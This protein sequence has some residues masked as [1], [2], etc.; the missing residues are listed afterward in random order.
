VRK[1]KMP[2]AKGVFFFNA[3]R[4][5]E[6]EWPKRKIVSCLDDIDSLNSQLPQYL[7]K[8]KGVK[9]GADTN[10]QSKA[11]NNKSKRVHV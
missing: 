3:L 1:K 6:S 7:G 10:I 11:N 8:R 5:P 9:D 2:I 4:D